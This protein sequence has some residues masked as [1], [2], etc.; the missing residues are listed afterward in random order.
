MRH[1]IIAAHP[2]A[3][4]F[5]RSVVETYIAT[6][7]DRGH[8]AAC[9][10]LYAMGFDPVLTAREMT[11]VARGRISKGVRA[12]LDAIRTADAITLVFPLWWRD[13]PAILK[14][15]LDRVFSAASADDTG[16]NAGLP[17]KTGAIIVTAERS[18]AELRSSGTTRALKALF[19]DGLMGYCG[20]VPAGHL[21]L[22]GIAPSMSRAEGARNLDAVRR[23]VCRT[24]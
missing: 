13:C 10:D 19:E 22:G 24:F 9:R 15:Y 17:V 4:S 18:V 6:L 7:H 16:P 1:L 20:I 21:Y 14:G 3:A 11:A 5:N 23:F 12:E 8:Q 2:R